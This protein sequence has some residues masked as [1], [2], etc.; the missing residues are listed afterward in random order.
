MRPH[1][2]KT[3]PL[4]QQQQQQQKPSVET[5]VLVLVILALQWQNQD[6]GEL[7]ASLGYPARLCSLFSSPKPSCLLSQSLVCVL[8]PEFFSVP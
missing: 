4:Q 1:L 2:K 3:K 8:W 7:K 5:S 6:G